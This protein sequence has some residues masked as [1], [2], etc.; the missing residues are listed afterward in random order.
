[1]FVLAALALL[2]VA[3]AVFDA[4]ADDVADVQH[5]IALTAEARSLVSAGLPVFDGEKRATTAAPVRF[6]ARK[7]EA[8]RALRTPLGDTLMAGPGSRARL[9]IG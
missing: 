7:D 1:L 6:Q 3:L 5:F 9:M 8:R 4:D 2:A